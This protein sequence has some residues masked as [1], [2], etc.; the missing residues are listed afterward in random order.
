MFI[1]LIVAKTFYKMRMKTLSQKKRSARKARKAI[2][3]AER[4]ACHEAERKAFLEAEREAERVAF[5]EA[6]REA[7]REARE[8]DSVSRQV[9]YDSKLNALCEA[10][11]KAIQ[12]ARTACLSGCQKVNKEFWLKTGHSYPI[13]EAC[14]EGRCEELNAACWAE[15]RVFL[16]ARRE[17]LKVAN[18]AFLEAKQVAHKAF[19]E[20]EHEEC[21]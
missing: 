3:K 10:K 12:L 19:L 8:A 14:H 4:I 21:T 17:A 16:R 6:E 13:P 9:E 7:E 15:V 5:L 18:E 1:I 2:L 20:A 11:S